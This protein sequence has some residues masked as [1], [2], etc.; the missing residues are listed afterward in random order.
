[1]EH[2]SLSLFPSLFLTF[3]PHAI[4]PLSHSLFPD[5]LLCMQ[6]EG[7]IS[8][9]RLCLLKHHLSE[10]NRVLLSLNCHQ[11]YTCAFNCESSSGYYSSG[12][13]SCARKGLVLFFICISCSVSPHC[14]SPCLP[15]TYG[16]GASCSSLTL[17]NGVTSPSSCSG[18]FGTTCTY[19]SC[20][21]GFALSSSGSTTRTC[22][23]SDQ[24]SGTA[25]WSGTEKTCDS[26]FF[27]FFLFFPCSA[28]QTQ[29]FRADK[30]LPIQLLSS[31]FSFS[32]SP[33]KT[34]T[35]VRPARTSASP[36]PPAA[37]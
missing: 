26:K 15:C 20:N 36:L 7:T 28:P 6:L 13:W 19:S 2:A 22:T 3:N 8:I 29:A 24:S 11:F 30:L 14:S 10:L 34:S 37:T 25:A 17:T 23:W 31:D 5:F 27:F 12:D 4:F 33:I 32:F 16:P 1:M 35:N 18:T 21:T 9:H